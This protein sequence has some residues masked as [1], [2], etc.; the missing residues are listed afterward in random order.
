VHRS[1]RNSNEDTYT[2]GCTHA[3]TVADSCSDSDT[4]AY[5]DRYTYPSAH[6]DFRSHSSPTHADGYPCPD[7]H[8]SPNRGPNGHPCQF[9]GIVYGNSH[10]VG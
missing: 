7:P 10:S 2:D 5:A 8:A 6:R 3:S 1:H 4:H 9:Q